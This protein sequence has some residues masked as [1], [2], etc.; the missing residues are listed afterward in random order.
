MEFQG[1]FTALVTPFQNGEVDEEAY[2]GLIEWQ[3]EQGIHGLVPCGTTG[4]SA[5]LSHAEHKKVV[6]ICVD[7]VKGRVPVLAGA[8][9]NNTKEAIELTR[10]AKDS[11]ADGALLITPYYNKPTQHGLIEHFAA[12]AKEVSMPF[13][14]YNVPGRTS[15]NLLPETLA[16]MEKRIP[17]VKG[18]KEATGDMSQCSRVLEFCS[19]AFR[20]L[21]GDDFTALSLYILGGCGVIS[22]VSNIMPG[23][24]AAMWN[25]FADGDLQKARE[26]HFKMA[27]LYRAMFLETNP[28]PAKTALG[29][30]GKLDFEARLPMVEMLPDNQEKLR[31]ALK[32]VDLI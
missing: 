16:K 29:W 14:V 7:Q 2:R 31:A 20:V 18:V 32:S 17:E 10:S 30:M 12:V 28:V 3:I 8:G 11:K 19:D 25:A 1:A 23:D 27:P 26:L 4:E 24:M 13:I 15:V 22:V 21:S 6:E 9:S 5:T